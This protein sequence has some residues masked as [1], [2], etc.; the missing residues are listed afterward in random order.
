MRTATGMQRFEL[1]CQHGK[2]MGYAIGAFSCKAD[3]RVLVEMLRLVKV[4][5]KLIREVRYL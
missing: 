4:H 5:E 1:K 2:P 3:D